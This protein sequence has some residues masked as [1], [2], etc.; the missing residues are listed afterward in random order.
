MCRRPSLYRSPADACPAENGPWSINPDLTLK[1]RASSWN[2]VSN[3]LFVDQPLQTGFSVARNRSE[4]ARTMANVAD[5]MLDFVLGWFKQH[6]LFQQ[7]EV[8]F[9]V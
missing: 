2:K 4:M 9:T 7:H 3:I 6:K 5:D 1:P 8:R